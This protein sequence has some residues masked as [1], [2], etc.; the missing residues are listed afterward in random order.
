MVFERRVV[1][2][3]CFF[4]HVFPHCLNSGK[5]KI[6]QGDKGVQVVK[7]KI[8]LGT[9]FWTSRKK[10]AIEKAR[11]PSYTNTTEATQRVRCQ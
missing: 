11:E 1:S 4:V 3:S 7:Y 5:V 10:K 2:R 9:R 6:S 8:V